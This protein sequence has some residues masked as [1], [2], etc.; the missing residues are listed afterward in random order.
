MQILGQL[1]NENN[2]G[3][4]YID[5]I[6]NTSHFSA[7]SVYMYLN[8][9]LGEEISFKCVNMR[10]ENIQINFENKKV[11]LK[12]LSCHFQTLRTRKFMLTG[13]N[14]L[15]IGNVNLLSVSNGYSK[16]VTLRRLKKSL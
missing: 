10:N 12:N 5:L 11:E 13:P 14:L 7:L 9:S 15:A 8:R 3:A 1:N 4:I 2:Q 6:N 16:I